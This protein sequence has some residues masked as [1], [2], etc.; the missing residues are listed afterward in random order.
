VQEAVKNLQPRTV[1]AHSA[2]L[3]DIPRSSL[4]EAALREHL[5]Q[6]SQ[7]RGITAAVDGRDKNPC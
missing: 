4:H 7:A 5:I 2:A 1:W 3:C 6:W